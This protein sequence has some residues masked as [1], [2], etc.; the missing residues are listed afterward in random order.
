MS[1]DAGTELGGMRRDFPSTCWSRISAA[2]PEDL[3]ARRAAVEDL[4]HRYWKPIYAYIRAKWGKTNE[5]AKDLTQ[6]FFVWMMEGDFI[7]RADPSRG[8]FRAYV[9]VAL[10][11]Y[12][13]D[14]E[15]RRQRLKRGGDREIL[16]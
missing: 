15:R 16:L 5:E 13:S 14:E 1:M 9:K 4:S 3:A 11:H 12:L 6:D 10:Q 8:R 7:D 2:F